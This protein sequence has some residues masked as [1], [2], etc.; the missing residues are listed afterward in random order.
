MYAWGYSFAGWIGYGCA[1]IPASSPNAQ[2]AWYVEHQC[3]ETVANGGARRFPLAFQVVPPLL[4]LCG[5]KF[6]PFSPR[7][8]LS[9]DRRKEAFD[10]IQRLHAD[11]NDPTHLEAREEYYLMEKQFEADKKLSLHR[12][13]EMFRTKANRRRALLSMALMV[14]D[15]FLGVYVLANY[16]VLIYASL[17]L[18]GY[19]P[20]LLNACWTTLT[21]FGNTW[22]AL[23]VSSACVHGVA[24]HQS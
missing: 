8:L 12:S 20:L 4:V 5:S 22:T 21:I 2:A 6:I 23:Y 10:I 13:F 14:F 24:K 19:T 7:W 18:T 3:S 9:Q 1:H 17:G 16:G 15:Q 11:K